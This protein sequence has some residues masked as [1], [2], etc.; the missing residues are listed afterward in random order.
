MH[1]TPVLHGWML[2]VLSSAGV[3]PA[4]VIERL[5]RAGTALAMA[6]ADGTDP[7][8]SGGTAPDGAPAAVLVG[9]MS[10]GDR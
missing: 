7:E 6:L 2:C 3:H 9:A 8:R 10:R 4:F 1:A 5:Q